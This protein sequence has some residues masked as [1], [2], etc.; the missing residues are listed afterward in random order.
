M[1]HLLWASVVLLLS[2]V[3][4]HAQVSIV[5]PHHLSVPAGRPEAIYHTALRVVTENFKMDEDSGLGFPLT[6]VLGE[7]NERYV[8]DED[9]K[10]DAIYLATWNE[11]KFAISVMRLA[12]E[13]LIDRDCRNQLVGEILSRSDAIAPVSVSAPRHR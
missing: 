7:E 9:R 1:R 8:E 12:M 11:K 13:H 10:I 3:G 6:L 2:S 5:N 4:L